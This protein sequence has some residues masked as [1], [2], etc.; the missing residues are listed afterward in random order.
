[1]FID[2]GVVDKV[3]VESYGICLGDMIVFVFDFIVMKN[4]KFL[5]VKVWDNCIGFVIVIEV[6]KNL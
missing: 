6:F 2:V 3:E 1:M 4:E 5:F